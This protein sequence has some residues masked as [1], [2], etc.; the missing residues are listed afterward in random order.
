M[1]KQF[2]QFYGLSFIDSEITLWL[3]LLRF[4]MSIVIWYWNIDWLKKSSIMV[5]SYINSR[6]FQLLKRDSRRR[7]IYLYIKIYLIIKL[8]YL[9]ISYDFYLKFSIFIWNV[10]LDGNRVLLVICDTT[11]NIIWTNLYWCWEF[12]HIYFIYQEINFFIILLFITI[13]SLHPMSLS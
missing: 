12:I 10:K 7:K 2:F 6:E 8:Q 3:M 4:N 13:T 9:Y 1:K 11:F 5:C